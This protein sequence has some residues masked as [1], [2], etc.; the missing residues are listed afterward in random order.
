MIEQLLLVFICGIVTV[1]TRALPFLI[2]R[3][4]DGELPPVVEYLGY[5]LPAALF[6]MLV[7]YCFKDVDFLHGNF[8]I[9]ELV[10]VVFTVA[11]HVKWRNMVLSIIVGTAFYMCILYS[12]P[13]L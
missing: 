2:Y 10:S 3:D 12:I 13:L 7:V 6:A 9:P 1:L 4:G 11:I 8:G 5:A